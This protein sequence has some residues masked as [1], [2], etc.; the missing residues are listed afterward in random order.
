MV[1]II[2]K[3]NALREQMLKHYPWEMLLSKVV[4]NTSV[5]YLK[6]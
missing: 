1:K 3:S 2:I 5:L 6:F 4:V